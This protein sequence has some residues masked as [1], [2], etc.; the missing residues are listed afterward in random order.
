MRS[1]TDRGLFFA[2]GV[3]AMVACGPPAEPC[4]DCPDVSGRY[5]VTPGNISSSSEGCEDVTVTLDP[6][7]VT[8]TQ[9]GSTLTMTTPDLEASGVLYEGNAFSFNPVNSDFPVDGLPAGSAT[10]TN[11]TNGTFEG[12]GPPW[13]A[14]GTGT[15]RFDVDSD[16]VTFDCHV[17]YP[18]TMDQQP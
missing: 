14:R 6:N 8:L 11:R 15:I 12:E 17:N 13:T 10:I 3:L 7:T 1:Y 2:V 5:L 4:T 16:Q 9:D 18:F